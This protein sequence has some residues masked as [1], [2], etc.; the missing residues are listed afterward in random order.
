MIIIEIKTYGLIEGPWIQNTADPQWNGHIGKA[1]KL[2][3][4]RFGCEMKRDLSIRAI[5]PYRDQNRILNPYKGQTISRVYTL[6]TYCW[7]VPHLN[8]KRRLVLSQKSSAM[9]WNW[10]FLPLFR[11]IPSE[12]SDI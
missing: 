10:I 8:I 2:V 5:F 3:K 9:N 12:T 11:S 1:F 6:Y 4:P 7:H